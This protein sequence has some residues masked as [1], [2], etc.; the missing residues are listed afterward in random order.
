MIQQW[1]SIKVE[2][3]LGDNGKMLQGPCVTVTQEKYDSSSK[4]VIKN[5]QIM[6]STQ[7]EWSSMTEKKRANGV[8][9]SKWGR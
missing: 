7:R 2:W 1:V 6:Y 8:S 3:Q 5:Y 4:K 9:T